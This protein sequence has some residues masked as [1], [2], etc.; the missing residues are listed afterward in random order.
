MQTTY[1]KLDIETIEHSL[2]D[3]ED[4]I[5]KLLDAKTSDGDSALHIACSAGRSDLVE[6]LLKQRADVFAR[7]AS[8]ATA[9]H[10]AASGGHSRSFM[11]LFRCL[12]I[13]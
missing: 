10:A 12:I 13:L 5:S 9:L 1:E 2:R 6:S 3:S 11:L 4:G 8:G 7:N